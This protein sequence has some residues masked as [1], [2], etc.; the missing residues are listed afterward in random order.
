MLVK[1]DEREKEARKESC[2]KFFEAQ[3]YETK[4]EHLIV[5]DYVFDDKICFE[6][7]TAKD[8]I[9]SIKDGRVFR[10]ARN[11]KQYPFSFVIIVG[12]VASEIN[13][14]NKKQYYKKGRFTVKAYLGA[15]ARLNT[16]SQVLI[17]DNRQQAWILMDSLVAKIMKDNVDV[18]MVDRPQNGLINP[19]ASFLSCIY[20]TEEKRLSVKNAL[21]ITE[22]FN[23]QTLEDLFELDYDKLISVKGI[24]H[25]TARAILNAI[26]N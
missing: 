9:G 11:M 13:N 22:E 3:G 20:I 14:Q 4:Q 12:N 6:Y 18:K 2:K 23:L 21:K 24:G 17:V 10:Q 8:M 7:K 5:G 19:I 15:I 26:I 25:S 16:Y 1:I